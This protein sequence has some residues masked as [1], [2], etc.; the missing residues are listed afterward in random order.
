MI[1][2][3]E[4]KRSFKIVLDSYNLNS[5]IGSQFNANYYINLQTIINDESAFDKQ[6]N[7]YCEFLTVGDT[8]ANNNVNLGALYSLQLQF[9]NSG[10]NTYQYD[11]QKNYNYLLPVQNLTDS[12]GTIHTL[13]RLDQNGQKPVFIQN[14]R[15]L[16]NILLQVYRSDNTSQ[17]IFSPSVPNNVKYICILTFV[18]A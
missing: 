15:N 12:A 11:P 16:T 7:V 1:S 6:Y 5:Y 2:S 9:N 18:E 10:I 3:K 17:I 4:V 13:L 8:P 14:I